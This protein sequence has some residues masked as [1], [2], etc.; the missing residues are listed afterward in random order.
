MFF[1]TPLRGF[2]SSRVAAHATGVAFVAGMPDRNNT[3]QPRSNSFRRFC[4]AEPCQYVHYCL[5]HVVARQSSRHLAHM[6]GARIK[7]CGSFPPQIVLAITPPEIGGAEPGS[8]Y[9]CLAYRL[10]LDMT[11]SIGSPKPNAEDMILTCSR[12]T[13]FAPSGAAYLFFAQR[14]G[15]SARFVSGISAEDRIRGAW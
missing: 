8:Y 10:L 14:T 7:A 3:N 6:Q 9:S 5:R 13:P 12:F 11:G 2:G 4:T 15:M 1:Q